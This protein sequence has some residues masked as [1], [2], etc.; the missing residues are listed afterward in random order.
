MDKLFFFNLLD[1][2]KI[3][4]KDL[5][6]RLNKKDIFYYPYYYTRKYSDIFIN[7]IISLLADNEIILLDN[8]FSREE[9]ENISINKEKLSMKKKVAYPPLKDMQDLIYRIKNVSK[10][11]ITLF[12]S[13]TT[14][15]PKKI[16]HTFSSITKE[17][18][19]S[20][21]KIDNIW[22][23]AYSPTHIAGLQVFFQALLNCN[24]I[25]NLFQLSRKDIFKVI[26]KY[27]I[28]NISATP[29]FYRQLLPFE[30]IFPSVERITFGGEKH[31]KKILKEVKKIF[32]KAKI[33][34]IY[35][36]T[37]T[38]TIFASKGDN[39][40]LKG[41]Y[42]DLI[43]IVDNEL[44]INKD[45]LGKFDL[46]ELENSSWYHTGDIVEIIKKNPLEFKFKYRK[47]EMINVG[48][49]KVSPY[50]VEEVI[51]KHP[52]VQNVVVYGKPN[53]VMGNLIHCDIVLK[54]NK[55][56]EKDV[57]LFLINKLQRFKI[58]R[59]INFVDNI[60]TARTGKVKRL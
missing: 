47:S 18:K 17:V 3:T 15:F 2:E 33:L 35:A 39:F 11:R 14:G 10:S 12:S 23:F 45:L 55:I 37:E 30:D 19:I 24:S 8:D 32:P 4:Y 57:R 53:S 1:N 26:K 22:G 27:Q 41:K 60:S 25:I 52:K 58:P 38:G 13:G 43:K 46:L 49:Y 16:T 6:C 59:V 44:L 5:L 42:K 31:D 36:L 9:L 21:D 7:I 54:D 29:T 51:R 20:K 48:G 28:T 34:N 56:A 40:M 50:E